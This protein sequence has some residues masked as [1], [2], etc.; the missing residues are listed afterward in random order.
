MLERFGGATPLYDAIVLSYAEE[1]ARLPHE[2]NALVL[3]TDGLDNEIYAQ[4]DTG[5]W[6]PQPPVLSSALGS[7]TSRSS[8][9]A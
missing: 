7:L 5:K 3:L 8:K 9:T 4:Q 1:I 2:R 6:G